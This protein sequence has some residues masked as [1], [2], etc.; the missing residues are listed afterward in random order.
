MENENTD[1]AII[2]NGH[3]DVFAQYSD[4][5]WEIAKSVDLHSAVGSGNHRCSGFGWC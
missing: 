4:R 5:R 2:E 1:L 3:G